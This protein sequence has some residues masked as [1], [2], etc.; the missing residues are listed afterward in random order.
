MFILLPQSQLQRLILL[1]RIRIIPHII[2]EIQ[3]IMVPVLSQMK[4]VY[5][6]CKPLGCISFIKGQPAACF[7]HADI[8]VLFQYV[9]HAPHVFPWLHF[10]KDIN[11]RLSPYGFHGCAA[12]MF[13]PADTV[14]GQH[15][16]QAMGLLLKPSGPI[17]TVTCQEN[18][19]Q[20]PQFFQRQ[21]S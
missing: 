21:F 16:F 8:P 19:K 5:T 10:H 17:L 6:L 13:H 14:H 7:R 4:V 20:L 1:S 9:P 15:A 2:P 3:L 11:N 18:R 12:H